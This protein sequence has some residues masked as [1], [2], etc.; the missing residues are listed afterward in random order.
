MNEFDFLKVG[1][2]H[3]LVQYDAAPLYGSFAHHHRLHECNDNQ[4]QCTL[5]FLKYGIYSDLNG[6]CIITLLRS[7]IVLRKA[8]F[9]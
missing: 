5:F 3:L 1:P 2:T 7:S 9:L 4:L 8:T 6:T